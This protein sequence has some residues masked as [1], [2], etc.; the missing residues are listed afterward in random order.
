[1]HRIRSLRRLVL[2]A[3]IAGA[4]IGAVPAMASAA[5]SQCTYDPVTH[6]ATVVA[7]GSGTDPLVIGSGGFITVSPTQL[8]I[9]PTFQFATVTNTD[10]IEVNATITHPGDGV[11]LDMEGGPFAP[12]VQPEADGHPEIEIAVRAPAGSPPARLEVFGSSQADVF[13]VGG[14]GRINLNNDDDTDLAYNRTLEKVSLAGRDGT[15]FLSGIGYGPFGATTVPLFIAGGDKDDTIFGGQRADVLGGG[16]GADTLRSQGDPSSGGEEVDGGADFDNAIVDSVD[17]VFS[18][19][20]QVAVG[21][22]TLAPRAVRARAGKVTRLNLSW[23]HPKAWRQLRTVQLQLYRGGE[24]LGMINASPRGERLSAAG[25]VKLARGSSVTH[26][27]KT[28]GV[29]LALRLARSLAGE[30]LR[31]A[32]QASDRHGHTQI[33]PAAGVINVAK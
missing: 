28:V 7:D 24:Q 1:M 8:C 14:S 27:G 16:P 23:T 9:S 21:R 12:G 29:H 31:V 3:A 13:R 25:A 19:E 10:R 30:E 6:V 32:V 4:A 26:H 15:D 2:G 18:V 20:S 33:E 11:R 5:A 17:R 22:L